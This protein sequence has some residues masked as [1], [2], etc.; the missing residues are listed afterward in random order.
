M[1]NATAAL[2]SAKEALQMI[3]QAAVKTTTLL[4]S[5]HH[6]D[7]RKMPVLSGARQGDVYV[8]RLATLED[9]VAQFGEENRLVKKD[10]GTE[11]CANKP[12]SVVTETWVGSKHVVEIT[13][14]HELAA[15]DGRDSDDHVRYLVASPRH[16]QRLWRSLH[17]GIMIPG[18]SLINLGTFVTYHDWK[19]TH[20]TEHATL[21]LPPGA[22]IISRQTDLMSRQFVRD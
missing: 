7:C 10:D 22:F 12:S 4:T 6:R 8:M 14:A 17:S 18:A 13:A 16:D 11:Q 15:L 1:S 3:H 9:I 2:P 20:A 5:R 21:I 19:L